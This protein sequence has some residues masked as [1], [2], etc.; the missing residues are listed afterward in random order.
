MKKWAVSVIILMAVIATGCANDST[1]QTEKGQS[2][3]NQ[4][5]VQEQAITVTISKDEGAE[6]LSEK[7]IE[8]EEGDILMD[9]MKE[10]FEI[11]EEEGFINSIDGVSPEE[12][13]QKAW[14][15]FVNDEVAMVGAEEYELEAE[16]RVVFDLQ[17][18][19]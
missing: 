16:D 14:M 18:W 10:N 5:E 7:E 3:E 1:P 8:I 17:E 15:Y 4:A 6:V 12:G 9:V 11:E 2:H 19:E 13:E